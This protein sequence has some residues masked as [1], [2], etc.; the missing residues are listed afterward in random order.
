MRRL[1][2]VDPAFH[3]W[4]FTRRDGAQER[5]AQVPLANPYKTV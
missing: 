1:S 2:E 3:N 5:E 4:A